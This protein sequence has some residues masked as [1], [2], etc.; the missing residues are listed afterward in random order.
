M[1]LEVYNKEDKLI[2]ALDDDEALLGSYPV[3]N[4]F[5]IHVIPLF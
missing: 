4:G 3:D 5:R 1:N 2:C